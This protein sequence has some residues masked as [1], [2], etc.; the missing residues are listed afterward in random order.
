MNENDI[1]L[2]EEWKAKGK[3]Y[4]FVAINTWTKRDVIKRSIAKQNGI[5]IKEFWKI[6]ELEEF[7]KDLN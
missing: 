3:K 5:C 7:L 1:A 4:Y 2:L 6:S